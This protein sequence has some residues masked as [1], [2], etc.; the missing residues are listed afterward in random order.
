MGSLPFG[1][2]WWTS[3]TLNERQTLQA[4]APPEP[5]NTENSATV[6]RRFEQWKSQ[7]PFCRE[8][9]F[10]RRLAF[11]DLDESSFSDLLGESATALQRRFPQVPS[12]LARIQ[13]AY[14]A[15]SP[16]RL[17]VVGPLI[18]SANAELSRKVEELARAWPDVDAE[19]GSLVEQL[20]SAMVARIDDRISRTVVLEMR[21]AALQGTLTGDD[22]SARFRTFLDRLRDPRHAL[23]FL[24]QY[25]VL[26]RTLTD[27]VDDWTEASIELLERVCADW[28]S[29]QSTFLPGR[30]AAL[31]S[32][33]MGLGDLHRRGR[34]VC[35]L[36]FASIGRV[37]YK[38]RSLAIDQHFALLLSWLHERGAP[39]LRLPRIVDRG[40]YGWSEFVSPA[41]CR[42][43]AEAGEFYLR[44][45]ALLAVLYLLNANDFHY[46][47]LIAAAGYPVPV[48]L[49]TLCGPDFGQ[50]QE[51]SYDSYSAFELAT[52]VVGTMLLPY[53][54]DNAGRRAVDRSGL[55]SREGQ[56]S[57]DPMPRWDHL[58]TDEA[59]LS[60]ER[61][62]LSA[63]HNRPE[64][65]GSALHACEFTA[66]VET[67]FSAMYRLLE[68][69]R[70]DLVS[71][72]GPL[73]AMLNDEVRVVFRATQFYEKILRQS[74]HPDYLSDALDRERLFDRLWFGMDRTQFPHITRRLLSSERQDLWRGEVPYFSTCVGSPDLT[75][76]D[77]RRI[78]QFFIR[79]GWD[80][81]QHRLA[82][83]GE[84]DLR[85]Q[86]WYIRASLST[87]ALNNETTF[88]RY[89]APVDARPADRDR[90]LVQATAIAQR[91]SRLARWREDRASW[92]GLAYGESR[93]WQLRPLQTDLYSGLP[94]VI[95][96][97]AY[98]ESLD[99]RGEFGAV[100]QGAM[101][102]LRQQMNRRRTG[103]E[104]IGGFDGWGGLLYLWAHLSQLWSD[105]GLLGETDAMVSRVE[106]LANSDDHLD[107][108]QGTAGAIVPLLNLHTMT[109]A[110]RPLEVARKLGDRLVERAQPATGGVG[111]LGTTFPTHPL[112][113]FSHGASGFAWALAELFAATGDDSYARTALRA[114]AFER[115][116]LSR[117]SGNWADLRQSR[118]GRNL[119][120]MTAWCHGA[121]GIGM[122][123]LRMLDILGD[124]TLAEDLDIALR[125]TYRQ[126]FGVNHSLCHGDLG[127]LDLLLQAGRRFPAAGWE[128]LLSE[129]VS[130]SLA[131][132]EEHGWRCGVPLDVETP[133]LMDGLAGIGYQLLRL[134][135]PDGIPSVLIL[136]GPRGVTLPA[137]RIST[138]SA[139]EGYFHHG[140][141]S[142]T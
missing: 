109:G 22:P 120:E 107:V 1:A 82:S 76:S 115:A 128:L 42:D 27:C 111:W 48:D 137:T 121:C 140:A 127:S 93:G 51:D 65:D 87:L 11:D 70:E 55:G 102:T 112:T 21:V 61:R 88:Q 50:A 85:T 58:G 52:S 25:P 135:E 16:S 96:F 79:S 6:R 94:G 108:I 23:L 98:T 106:S 117:D 29:I 33:E 99:G 17:P 20:I 32:I 59:R 40:S 10:V 126:G 8:D 5:S 49:E 67:G 125:T 9:Y 103:S 77:G 64:L 39:A 4:V 114:V 142:N 83:L 74:Y 101:R 118:R 81:V 30:D 75:A 44:Q 63:G 80:M 89:Q 41:P 104:G 73:T 113:G 133:G 105:P 38:P 110:V 15:T 34:E 116:H 57:A 134:A 100:A 12:W 132:M 47:N 90:L 71:P 139:R 66:E 24:A 122:S 45:G 97:L 2:E 26:A 78:D 7:S 131:G 69:N 13:S 60:F 14:S 37:L 72:A 68:S 28:A 56:L 130:S 54:D 43:R 31:T 138:S 119:R 129:R 35:V 19:W 95:L 91:I 124:S 36:R 141:G 86:L 136:E 3:L 123:R 92:L 53:S 62:T 84:T 18:E 46:A